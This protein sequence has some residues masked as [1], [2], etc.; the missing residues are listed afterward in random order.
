MN[1]LDWLIYAKHIKAMK[2]KDVRLLSGFVKLLSFLKWI[3]AGF[4]VFVL[5]QQK[6]SWVFVLRT[7]HMVVMRDIRLLS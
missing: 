4:W 6:A 1:Q 7:S 3:F 5:C 2:N